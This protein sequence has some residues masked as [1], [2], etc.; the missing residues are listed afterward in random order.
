M[1]LQRVPTSYAHD[2]QLFPGSTVVAL[3]I[4]LAFSSWEMA[5]LSHRP[6]D[7]IIDDKEGQGKT[8]GKSPAKVFAPL[9]DLQDAPGTKTES[10]RQEEE[11]PELS[12]PLQ[13]A[14]H[15]EDLQDAPETKIES[16]QEESDHF[17]P[18]PVQRSEAV[19]ESR[20]EEKGSN[21]VTRD[22]LLNHHSGC[23]ALGKI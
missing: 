13:E 19:T 1:C 14:P 21:L 3:G 22:S 11:A 20:Q 15:Q 10:R 8:K 12:R 18:L 6:G 9:R 23:C 16:R 17:Q 4:T 5:H 2:D 7:P